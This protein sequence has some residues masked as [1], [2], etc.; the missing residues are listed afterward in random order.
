MLPFQ[1]I[2]HQ[3]PEEI[4]ETKRATSELMAMIRRIRSVL[5]G[6]YSIKA[7][8]IIRT[9]TFRTHNYNESGRHRGGIF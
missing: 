2:N 3:N 4:K 6:S 5:D 7:S 8:N 1:A 9:A